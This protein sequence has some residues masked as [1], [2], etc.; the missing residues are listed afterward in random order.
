MSDKL[1]AYFYL[2]FCVF[3]WGFTA[4]LGK[5]ISLKAVPLGVVACT[6]CQQC[7]SRIYSPGAVEAPDAGALFFR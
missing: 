7:I 1:R 2:H 3:I 5:L 6:H 4:I